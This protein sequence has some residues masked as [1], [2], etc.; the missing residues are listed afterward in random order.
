[1]LGSGGSSFVGADVVLFRM[2][3]VSRPDSAQNWSWDARREVGET[4]FPKL[5]RRRGPLSGDLDFADLET[6]R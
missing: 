3:G 1:M 5:P 4:V 6:C 2:D